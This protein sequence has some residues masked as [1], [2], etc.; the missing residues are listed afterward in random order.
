MDRILRGG[1]HRGLALSLAHPHTH[2]QTYGM[3]YALTCRRLLFR[4]G[5]ENNA[6]TT[7]M[8]MNTDRNV[9]WF[10]TASCLI[11]A[12]ERWMWRGYCLSKYILIH[13]CH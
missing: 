6:I 4:V 3:E 1:D 7:L 5:M 12:R 9:A 2:K 10:L 11:N 13:M 8:T